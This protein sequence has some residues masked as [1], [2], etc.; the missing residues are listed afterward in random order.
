MIPLL[1]TSLYFQ[2]SF[3]LYVRCAI[4]W[5]PKVP[6][7]YSTKDFLKLSQVK[8]CMVSFIYCFFVLVKEEVYLL[9]VK[10]KVQENT[11]KYTTHLLCM[12]SEI[13]ISS[14]CIVK[15]HLKIL[16]KCLS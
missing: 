14:I 5:Y 11:A 1:G 10:P 16:L 9:K 12:I 13:E 2:L 6:D 3:A 7:Q 4:G 8:A 15:V